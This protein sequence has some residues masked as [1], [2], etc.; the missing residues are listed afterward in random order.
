MNNSKKLAFSLVELAAVISIIAILLSIVGKTISTLKSSRLSNARYIT[1]NSK[2]AE[3]SNLVAWYETSL[4]ESFKADETQNKDEL[5]IWN[6]ISPLSLISDPNNHALSKTASP[7]ITFEEKGINDLP[8]IKFDGSANLTLSNF[9]EGDLSQATIFIVARRLNS[10]TSTQYI[11]DSAASGSSF[12]AGISNDSVT[13]NAGIAANSGAGSASFQFNEDVV[14]AI[15]INGANSRAFSNNADDIIGGG[16]I[17]SGS[18]IMTGLTLGT[19]KDGLSGFN[20]LISEIIIFNSPLP[21]Y[22][23]RDIM[24]YLSTKYDIRINNL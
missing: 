12:A 23:R 9:Q 15:Y 1:N 14:L 7:N 6:D 22:L 13:I 2:I 21:K 10:S 11:L 4:I 5:T 18:N 19:D 3:N 8:S 17:D 24:K 16:D 20:G